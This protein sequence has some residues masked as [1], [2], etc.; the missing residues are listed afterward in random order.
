MAGAKSPSTL[1]LFHDN[2]VGG[3]IHGLSAL[4]GTLYRYAPEITGVSTA[5]DKKVGQIAGDGTGT[6]LALAVESTAVIVDTLAL[7][8]ARVENAL[9]QAADTVRAHGVPV[10]PDG[11]VPQ[12]CL[13]NPAAE[14]WR[15]SCQ[16]YWQH[17]MDAARQ[18]RVQAA[19]DLQKT[20]SDV[21][22]DHGG[23]RQT[24]TPSPTMCAGCGR[25][26][27]LTANTSRTGSSPG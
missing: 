11:K 17:C 7:N 27:P 1:P 24:A 18:A 12:V 16:S 9:E 22:P 4:A 14:Q 3:N 20:Y 23:T 13:S 2:W 10:G 21:G 8:L 6:G 26:R 5:L 19:S 15:V 25:S